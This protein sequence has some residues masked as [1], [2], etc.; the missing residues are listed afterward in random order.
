[1]DH[2]HQYSLRLRRIIVKYPGLSTWLLIEV[3]VFCTCVAKQLNFSNMFADVFVQV[4][5]RHFLFKLSEGSVGELFLCRPQFNSVMLSC[6]LPVSWDFEAQLLCLVDIFV[7]FSL[8]GMPV[9]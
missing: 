2:N 3:A 1:M 6:L 8:T 7:S 4:S 5:K 9:N